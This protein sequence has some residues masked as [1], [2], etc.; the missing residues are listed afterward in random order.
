MEALGTETERPMLNF[1]SALDESLFDKINALAG[2]SPELDVLVADIT[3][4]PMFKGVF[5][6]LLFWAFGSPAIGPTAADARSLLPSS[7]SQR[8]L[9]WQVEFWPCPSPSVSARSTTPTS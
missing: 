4:N 9:S 8:S 5:V 2:T 6:M 1:L 7:S 3:A